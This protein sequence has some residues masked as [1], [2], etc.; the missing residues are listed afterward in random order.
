MTAHVRIDAQSGEPFFYTATRPMV[1]RQRKSPIAS[2]TRLAIWCGS[3]GS[4]APYCALMHDLRHNRKPR[5][6]FPIYPTT[7]DLARLQAGGDH[8]VHEM[9]RHSWLGVMP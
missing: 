9:N 7:C 4:T 6:L 1:Q 8:W 2:P 5:A 3:S